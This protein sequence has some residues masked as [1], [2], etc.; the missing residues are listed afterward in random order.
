MNCVLLLFI[1]GTCSFIMFASLNNKFCFSWVWYIFSK[2]FLIVSIN[3]QSHLTKI[4]YSD[5][6]KLAVIISLRTEVLG[7]QQMLKWHKAALKDGE[8][9]T[10]GPTADADAPWARVSLCCWWPQSWT[11]EFHFSP[12]LPDFQIPPVGGICYSKFCN[13]LPPPCVYV[14][15]VSRR[16]PQSYPALL[17]FRG[18]PYAGASMA[19]WQLCAKYSLVPALGHWEAS[20][21][22]AFPM[23][24]PSTNHAAVPH[25]VC[26]GAL[27]AVLSHPSPTESCWGHSKGATP[28]QAFVRICIIMQ[29]VLSEALCL[30]N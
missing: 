4:N 8:G 6:W 2:L 7:D 11:T 29:S 30:L 19:V 20:A 28:L 21:N 27:L 17:F 5:L 10:Q 9:R 23:V 22:Y 24:Q 26:A 15:S 18:F 25:C 1:H 3:L 16:W 12:C 14:C 13:W